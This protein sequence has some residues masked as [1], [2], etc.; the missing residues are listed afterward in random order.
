[1]KLAEVAAW[2]ILCVGA[3]SLLV[4]AVVSVLNFR[5]NRR[6]RREM[7]EM[8]RTTVEQSALA[9]S[10]S[11]GAEHVA[12]EVGKKV[13]T[14]IKRM[15]SK[16]P[17]GVPPASS[18]LVALSLGL[19]AATLSAAAVRLSE[20][21]TMPITQESVQLFD[22][23]VQ[24][25]HYGRYAAARERYR[26]AAGAGYSAIY[27][28]EGVAECSFYLGDY[29]VCLRACEDLLNTP[30]GAGRGRYWRGN[31]L[32]KQGRTDDACLEFQFSHREGYQLA[33]RMLAHVV[34]TANAS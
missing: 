16:P 14:L 2:V 8:Q 17:G 29:G 26:R 27:S 22:A 32:L 31:V 6:H 7:E 30:G 18:M 19:V 25:H 24:D 11:V 34:R 10:R 28:L 23:A 12:S 4:V 20:V 5:D 13:D 33:G 15:E 3:L 21:K 9:G 1:M